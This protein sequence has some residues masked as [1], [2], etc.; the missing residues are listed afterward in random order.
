MFIVRRSDTAL[1][2]R[3]DTASTITSPHVRQVLTTVGLQE[4]SDPRS[5]EF[6]ENLI[7]I[8]F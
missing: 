6:I 5:P 8:S 2:K 3:G 1:F 7:R 4:L